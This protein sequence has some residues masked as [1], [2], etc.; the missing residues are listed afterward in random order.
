MCRGVRAS[1]VP[2][3]IWFLARECAP[4]R[5]VG[6]FYFDLAT[7]NLLHPPRFL[8]GHRVKKAT[9]PETPYLSADSP[10]STAMTCPVM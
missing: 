3:S 1:S 9:E 5:F 4:K 10:P 2:I 6:A 7:P 8:C